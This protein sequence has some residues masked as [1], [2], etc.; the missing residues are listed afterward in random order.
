MQ[1]EERNGSNET[2]VNAKAEELTQEEEKDLLE[3]LRD[4]LFNGSEEKL[5]VALGRPI[6]E[7]NAWLKGDS[8]IDE[9]AM[10]KAH[11]LLQER[12]FNEQ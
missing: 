8:Q 2:T 11:G 10:L 6:T 3:R 12:A 5:S 7:I 4:Q 1:T 9:D